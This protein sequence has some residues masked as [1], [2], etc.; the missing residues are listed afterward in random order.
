M[1]CRWCCWL[2]CWWCCPPCGLA[3][4]AA[5]SRDSQ[6]RVADSSAIAAEVLN[7]IPVVQLHCRAARSLALCHGSR[8]AFS[9]AVQ[10]T[11]A[12]PCW[13]LSSSSPTPPCC[14]GLYRGHAGRAGGRNDRGHLGQT[15]VYVMLLAG[16]VAVLGEVYGDLL[17]AAGATER[18]MELL[19]SESPVAEPAAPCHCRPRA[20][21]GG[22]VCCGAVSL[23]SRPDRPALEDFSL[24]LAPGDRGL[25]GASGAGKTTV[26]QLLQRFYDIERPA[27]HAQRSGIFF[28]GWTFGTSPSPRCAATLPPFP[29]TR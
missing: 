28:N 15:V 16:A 6:D 9:T 14:W 17:R 18:L 11:R 1:S 24:T 2:C 8:S 27:G 10:R 13:W 29:R 12:R 25:V 23:P 19:A 3:G 22:R 21:A 7:A 26:F 4:R 20:G 5:A